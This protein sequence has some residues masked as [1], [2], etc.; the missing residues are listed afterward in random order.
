MSFIKRRRNK[1]PWCWSF[2]QFHINF[3]NKYY[4]KANKLNK[5]DYLNIN[6]IPHKDK[7]ELDEYD[8]YNNR[9]QSFSTD[10]VVKNKTGL[11]MN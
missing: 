9:I 10:I 1:R 6:K 2:P 4:K 3:N 11:Y 5:D 8:K 7:L